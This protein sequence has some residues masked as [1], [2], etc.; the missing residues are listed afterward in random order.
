[1]LKVVI[2][3][4][5]Y[6]LSTTHALLYLKEMMVAVGQEMMST[7]PWGLRWRVFMGA[8]LSLLDI[9]T[10]VYMIYQYLTSEEDGQAIFGYINAGMVA[11]SL[12]FQLILVFAQN[13]KKG[14]KKVVYEAQAV[15]LFMKPAVDA[16]RVASGAEH[17]K[18]SAFS[19]MAEL[20]S[21]KATEMVRHQGMMK[22][23]CFPCF[24]Y[25]PPCRSPLLSSP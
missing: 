3:P 23:S 15:F 11:T 2:P 19:H 5:S 25:P 8:K 7:V 4:S 13:K 16:F 22:V 18:G 1:M 10:D 21:T 9:I 14:K 6:S 20:V 24:L 17:E 12:L